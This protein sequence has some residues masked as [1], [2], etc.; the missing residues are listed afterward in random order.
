MFQS[1]DIEPKPQKLK[2]HIYVHFTKSTKCDNTY[3][4]CFW[5]LEQH[6]C[7]ILT[8]WRVP[9]LRYRAHAKKY[10]HFL[11][12]TESFNHKDIKTFD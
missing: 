4:L 6:S 1:L 9:K 2:L 7:L 5:I 3:K 8:S 10:K 12:C 11:H